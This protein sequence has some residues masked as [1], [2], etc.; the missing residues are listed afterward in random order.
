MTSFGDIA[1]AI[2]GEFEQCPDVFRDVE[3][4]PPGGGGVLAS[5]RNGLGALG[6]TSARWCKCCGKPRQRGWNPQGLFQVL[7]EEAHPF[8]K[9]RRYSM[10]VQVDRWPRRQRRVGRVLPDPSSN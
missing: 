5:S 4:A 2:T 7:L 6:G 8:K 3:R 1:M 10:D 9:T